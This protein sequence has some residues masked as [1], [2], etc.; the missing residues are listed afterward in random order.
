MTENKG[1][2]AMLTGVAA[3][4]LVLVIGIAIDLSRANTS[5]MH[6]SNA[7]D[8]ALIAA[9]V[10]LANGADANAA[11][12]TGEQVFEANMLALSITNS[13]ATPVFIPDTVAQ[14]ITG[15]VA[16]DMPLSF[17]TLVG[18]DTMT[19]R[20]AASAAYGSELIEVALMLD[21]SGSMRGQRLTDLKASANSLIDTLIPVS[22]AG[23]VRI[24]LAPYAT[25]VNAGM[26]GDVTTGIT[27]LY[28]H[29]VANLG[30]DPNA[31]VAALTTSETSADAFDL[32][33]AVGGNTGLG[34]L[35]S[36]FFACSSAPPPAP[37]FSGHRCT[38]LD[39]SWDG[40]DDDDWQPVSIPSIPDA[41]YPFYGCTSLT[42]HEDDDDEDNF[43]PPEFRVNY[44]AAPADS[45][46]DG[47]GTNSQI[48]ADW[49][50]LDWSAASHAYSDYDFGI[51]G[52]TH[53]ANIGA[54]NCVTERAGTNAF[55]DV[56]PAS[57]PVGAKSST[58][59]NAAVEPL[60]HN[61][62]ILKDA[63][64]ALHADG[65]TAGHLGIAWSWYTLSP[66]W[67]TVW[68]FNRRSDS[69]DP[70][71]NVR[72]YAILMTDGSFNTYYETSQGDSSAQARSLCTAMKADGID[73]YAVA[74]NAP[75][76]AQ[77]VLGDCATSSSHFFTATD[78]AQLQNVYDTIA[79][80]LNQIR[81]T[82]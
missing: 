8:S 72:R 22:G 67:N 6:I 31:L 1:N 49:Q 57:Y 52:A 24:S 40:C 43:C 58:C 63:I 34:S 73:I 77:A 68:P 71:K 78:G 80:S 42:F 14:T 54:L 33:D 38:D 3:V 82:H 15:S 20:P 55:T 64:T 65:W 35:S 25:A 4:P 50:A 39:G 56:S 12:A 46:I 19:V 60:T 59:P 48:A 30:A 2:I 32:I 62:T 51:L 17:S 26:Y 11:K 70:T 44:D 79:A 18:K 23:K 5:D 21:V 16:C 29:T 10:D 75:S 28:A 66:N 81:L 45:C 53:E 27:N 61:T 7:L 47:S 76:D 41:W 9:A 37:S 13:C 69:N 74:F 36:S